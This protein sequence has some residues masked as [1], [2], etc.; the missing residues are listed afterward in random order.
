LEEM[1]SDLLEADF[2]SVAGFNLPVKSVFLKIIISGFGGGIENSANGV[3]E[4]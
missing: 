4:G 3:K 1:S 2:W